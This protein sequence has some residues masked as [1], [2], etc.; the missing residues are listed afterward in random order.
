M[1]SFLHR[2][3]RGLAEGGCIFFKENT[4]TVAGQGSF[5]VDKEDNSI[6]RSDAHYKQLFH[7]AGMELVREAR[8]EEFPQELFDVKMYCLR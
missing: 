1:I 3:R 8:Q 4:T 5:I 6:T 7:D 2:C